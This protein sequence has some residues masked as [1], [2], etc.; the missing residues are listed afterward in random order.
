MK[1]TNVQKKIACLICDFVESHLTYFH[2]A[3]KFIPNAFAALHKLKQ[4]IAE[5]DWQKPS[6]L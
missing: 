1:P 6:V 2:G 5:T 3:E 4:S